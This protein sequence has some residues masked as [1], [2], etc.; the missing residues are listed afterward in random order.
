MAQVHHNVDIL[1]QI[2]G[3]L[4]SVNQ[5][6]NETL[7]FGVL[8]GLD[9][10]YLVKWTFSPIQGDVHPGKSCRHTVQGWKGSTQPIFAGT[11]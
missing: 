1:E 6:I 5:K 9:V 8:S 4:L 3:V 10:L 7:Y 11:N 2:R